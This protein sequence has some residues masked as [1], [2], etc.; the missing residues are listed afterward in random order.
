VLHV[1]LAGPGISGHQAL[2]DE[3][4][5]HHEV[6]LLPDQMRL[7]HSWVLHGID[8]LVLDA[9]GIR[10]MLP[11]LLRTLHLLRA[12]LPIVLVDGG[13]SEHEK[14]D[15]FNLGVLDYFA[16][17]YHVGLLAERLEVLARGREVPPAS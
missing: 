6:T 15:A 1:C 5:I 8:V 3:L 12:D 14:A 9:G 7:E 10:A 17:P 2:V 4:R 13:L 11:P 16:P